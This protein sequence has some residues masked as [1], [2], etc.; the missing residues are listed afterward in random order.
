MNF[1]FAKNGHVLIN[2]DE[3]AQ[4]FAARKDQGIWCEAYFVDLSCSI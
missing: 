1:K 4:C 2:T 3:P